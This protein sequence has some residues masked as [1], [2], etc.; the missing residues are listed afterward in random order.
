MTW[1]E[2]QL[3]GVET[4][5]E[6]PFAED[7]YVYLEGAENGFYIPQGA[8]GVDELVRRLTV[9]PAF[10][11]E[12]FANAMCSTSSARFVCWKRPEP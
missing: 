5:P 7:V 3:V 11:N 9:L 2:L 4:T 10:N 6:G 12:A 1:A 8:E